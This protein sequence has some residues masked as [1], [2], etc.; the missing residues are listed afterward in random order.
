MGNK[1]GGHGGI[2]IGAAMAREMVEATKQEI[3]QAAEPQKRNV[4]IS[5]QHEDLND[6]NL[7][8]AQS[9]N[10]NSRLTFN[11]WSL[12]EPFDS[13]QGDYIRRGIR[14]RIRQA[15]VTVVYVGDATHQS[16]WVDWE[17]RETIELG[18]GVVAVHKGTTPPKRLP[19]VLIANNIPV[20]PWSTQGIT[21]AI[22]HAT[23]A[24]KR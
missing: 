9:A 24:R 7:L 21:D 8:R 4:F 3:G 5:F 22:E 16:K 18:K 19:A 6:V 14:E 2:S 17:V 11:D 13:E 10:D 20:I 23:L 12:K 1:A 15:S